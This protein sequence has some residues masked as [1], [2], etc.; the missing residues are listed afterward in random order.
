VD[1]QL[2]LISGI[3]LILHETPDDVAEVWK[4]ESVENKFYGT[5]QIISRL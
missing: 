4:F 3:I 1:L 5:T 2:L